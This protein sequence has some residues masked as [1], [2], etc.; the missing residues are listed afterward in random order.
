[1]DLTT[2]E[3]VFLGALCAS[4]KGEQYHC[5]H[6]SILMM[7]DEEAIDR[8]AV[9]GNKESGPS[10]EPDLC[11]S[12]CNQ[13]IVMSGLS[14]VFT[15]SNKHRVLPLVFES[16][17]K[18]RLAEAD[19]ALFA[20]IKR[21][22]IAQVL[23]QTVRSA[24][25]GVLYGKLRAAGL[26]PIVV[27]GQ[28]CNRLYPLSDHRLT[29]DD[30]IFVSEAEFD[31]C[32]GILEA[33]GM[34]TDCPAE[35]I[36]DADEVSYKREGSPLYIE[37]HRRL[38]DSSEDACDDLNRFFEGAHDRAV[39]IDGWLSLPPHEHLLYLLLHAYKHFVIC[40]IGIRQF[41]DIGLWAREYRGEIDWQLLYRQCYS[42][43]AATFASVA[44]NVA[45][46][47]LGIDIDLPD[48]W[49]TPDVPCEPLLADVLRG[50]IYGSDDYTRLHS[51]TVTLN[52]V[53][54]SRR[55]KR[56]NLFSTLFPP[57]S[58]LVKDY[59]YL[60]RM[61]WLLPVAWVQRFFRYICET[62]KTENNSARG[63]IKLARERI[64]LMRMYDIIE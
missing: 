49:R 32:R 17:R 16:V 28:L 46:E 6:E 42:V 11:K 53:R 40:G 7:V 12:F 22:V 13:N 54:Q 31:A 19:P 29:A 61:P 58:Y 20:A 51:S 26:H 25:F 15:L 39:D 18:T 63:S 3:T 2:T 62:R 60:R 36:G 55:G 30:D 9:G 43:H 57:R 37:L 10:L 4:L 44:F 56:G 45:N 52:A 48:P 14:D 1:M 23:T 38:F 35:S 64:E 27:K 5:V 8:T 21:Q 24:E 33:E 59:P 50:G 47:Y 41:C 34:V